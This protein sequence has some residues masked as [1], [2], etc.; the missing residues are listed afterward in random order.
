M[1]LHGLFAV[2]C[3]AACAASAADD[4]AKH[5]ITHEDLW[6]MKRVGVPLLSPD[7]RLVAVSVAQPAYDDSA[8]SSDLWLIPADGSAPPRQLTFSNGAESGATWS[9]IRATRWPS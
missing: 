1:K 6:L 2:L 9:A 7:G 4:A 5:P 8:K 3:L